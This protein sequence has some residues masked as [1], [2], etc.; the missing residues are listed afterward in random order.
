[1]EKLILAEPYACSVHAVN[2]GLIQ[3][4]DVVVLSGA[5]PLGL[6]MVGAARLKNPSKLIVLDGK[7]DRLELA[8]KFGADIVMNP[9]KDPELSS[10]RRVRKCER[11]VPPLRAR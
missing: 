5:G 4:D 10:L 9:F 8:K 11:S 3:L 6:G 7:D 1:M 2:R